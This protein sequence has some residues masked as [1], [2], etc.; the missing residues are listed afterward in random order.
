MDRRDT[1][2]LQ[3]D[4]ICTFWGALCPISGVRAVLLVI[5]LGR[6]DIEVI[7]QDQSFGMF[8][9]RGNFTGQRML[10]WL[11]LAWQPMAQTHGPADQGG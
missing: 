5:A 2:C 7:L 6:V 10:T 1:V 8:I 4:R 9:G 3:S 11:L